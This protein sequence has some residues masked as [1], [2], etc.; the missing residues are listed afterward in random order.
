MRYSFFLVFVLVANVV[1][2]Q[3]PA[4]K[5]RWKQLG[6]FTTPPTNTAVGKSTA[7]GMGWVQDLLITKQ[8]WFAGS[9]TG[10]LYKSKTEGKKWKKIDNDTVQLGTLC[11]LQVGDTVYRGTGVTHYDVDFGVGLLYSVNAGKTWQPTGLSFDPLQTQPLWDVAADEKGTMVA[12]TPTA[13]YM[14][15][16]ASRTW[17]EVYRDENVN[18]REVLID[19]SGAMWAC[20]TKLLY[21]TDGQN[22]L[23]RTTALSLTSKLGRV[24]LVQD[25]Q[26]T[27][28]FLA[29]YGEKRKGVIDQSYDGGKTWN[30]L[31][32]NRLISR[33][34]IHHTAIGIAPNDSNTIVLGTYRAYV[35]TDGGVSFKVA[36]TPKKYAVNFA[37]DD[38]R[39]LYVL[40][41]N[42][43]YL[44]TDGGVFHS[45]D[46]GDTWQNKT[47]KGLTI[48]QIYGMDQMVNG[49]LIMGCQDLGYFY[50]KANK[51]IHLGDYYGDGGDALQNSSG[52]N[53]MLGGRL[54]QIDLESKKR[55]VYIHPSTTASPFTAK[56]VQHPQGRDTFYYI[57]T[58]VWLYKNEKKVNLTKEID[59]KREIVSGFDIN[60]LNPKQLIFAYNQPTWDKT[61]LT[62]KLHKSMDGGATWVDLTANMPLLAWRHVTGVATHT[63]HPNIITVSLGK[64]DDETI[65]KAMRSIDGG[66]TWR[67]YSQGLPRYETFGIWAIPNTTGVLLASLQGLYYRNDKMDAWQQVKGKIPAVAVRDIAIDVKTRKTYAATYG[68]GM[69]YFKMPRKMLKY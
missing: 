15:R 61:K 37:H 20:G 1:Q 49:D 36:T 2:A 28:R 30:R 22:W 48:T 66:I 6:P 68:S 50:Y 12:C 10:G 63:Q 16:D 31:Y 23:D 11:L 46:S 3:M 25:P 34:D 54:R 51:W 13:I 47:G 57:G 42:D 39:N 8:G 5:Y 67:D 58:D 35:S 24:S 21:S 52:M 69:W 40:A 18:L 62:G 32:S 44:A 65:H 53:I 27:K 64:L 56:L 60:A 19:S 17:Q 41:S 4:K 26:N 7:V 33:A 59:G 45:R 43:I 29:F 14:S 38:I 55:S 9:M